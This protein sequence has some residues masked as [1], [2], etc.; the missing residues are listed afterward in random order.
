MFEETKK[1]GSKL[2]EKQNTEDYF[3]RKNE[4]SQGLIRTLKKDLQ[5]L[6]DKLV[7]A[8]DIIKERDNEMNLLKSNLDELNYEDNKN[9]EA[10][11]KVLTLIDEN[12]YLMNLDSQNQQLLLKLSEEN[13]TLKEEMEILEI[14]NSKFNKETAVGI[15][16]VS[17]FEEIQSTNEFKSCEVCKNVF[18][19]KHELKSHIETC[20]KKVYWEQFVSQLERRISN[21]KEHLLEHIFKVRETEIHEKYSCNSSC[22]SGCRIFHQKHDWV[23]SYSDQ[24]I[25]LNSNISFFRDLF[26]SR[27]SFIS[28]FNISL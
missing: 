18:E 28:D 25:S 27:T 11:G 1:F 23:R 20:H 17:L 12:E 24:F 16:S 21:Q 8:E 10:K 7:E 5:K 2:E 13:G 14:E 15:N 9:M 19:Y 26:C 4:V 3:V 22:K 6:D